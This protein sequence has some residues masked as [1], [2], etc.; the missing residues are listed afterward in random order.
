MH[1]LHYPVGNPGGRQSGR[2]CP[3]RLGRHT[4]GDMRCDVARGQT[5]GIQRQHDRINARQSPFPLGYDHDSKLHPDPAA[6]QWLPHQSRSTPFSRASRLRE[7]PRF[8]PTGSCRSYP[9]C[10]A[11]SSSKAVSSTGLVS[12]FNNPPGPVNATRWARACRTDSLAA[13]KVLSRRRISRIHR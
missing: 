5:A 2:W 10:S 12:A 9:G 3:W 7:L 8:R 6:P 4:S 13:A 1:L 11:I